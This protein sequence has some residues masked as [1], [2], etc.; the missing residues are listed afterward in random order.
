MQPR[1]LIRA[2]SRVITPLTF[3]I[4]RHTRRFPRS[5][6]IYYGVQRLLGGG[7][8]QIILQLLLE[9]HTRCT[10]AGTL[11]EHVFDVLC[12]RHRGKQVMGENLLARLRVEFGEV[13]RC[14][15]EQNATI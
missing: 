1:Y 15:A 12:E 10:V 9:A 6:P 13:T 14:G 8:A 4:D 11:T 2:G 5:A 7:G 3:R